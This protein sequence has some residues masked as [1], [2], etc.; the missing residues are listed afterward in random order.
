M[1]FIN[2]F[3]C[4]YMHLYNIIN[5]CSSTADVAALKSQLLAYSTDVA[6][7]MLY[8]THKGFIHRDLAARNI[9]ITADKSC[10]VYIVDKHRHTKV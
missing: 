3:A 8:L 2:H 6:R 1:H 9:L 7:G 5:T 4:A 10:K